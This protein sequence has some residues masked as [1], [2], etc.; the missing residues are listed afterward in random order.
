MTF[1]L[2]QIFNAARPIR[3]TSQVWAVTRYQDR[4]SA[5][6]SQTKFRGET[7]SGV[8]KCQLFSQANSDLFEEEYATGRCVWN[9]GYRYVW[10]IR[11]SQNLTELGENS[12]QQRKRALKKHRLARTWTQNTI[13]INKP[14]RDFTALKRSTQGTTLLWQYMYQSLR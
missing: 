2:K 1:H 10:E 4:I 9:S 3:S 7:K 14:T 5:L 8:A 12:Q 13:T 11:V 6:V